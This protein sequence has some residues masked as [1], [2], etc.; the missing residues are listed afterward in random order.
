MYF[1]TVFAFVWTP[2]QALYPSEVLAYN[3]R[4]KG[5]AALGLLINIANFFNTC[6]SITLVLLIKTE[7]DCLDVDVPPVAIRNVG[8]RFYLFYAC[9][10]AFGVVVIY[11]T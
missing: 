4:A 8:W 10:D 11:F 7:A 3:N 2:M 6:Q 5:L 9:W 1:A